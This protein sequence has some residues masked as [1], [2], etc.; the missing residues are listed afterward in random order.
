[1]RPPCFFLL[2]VLLSLAMVACEQKA[3]DAT[4]AN[5]EAIAVVEEALG[6]VELQRRRWL[7]QVERR[8]PDTTRGYARWKPFKAADLD[9]VIERQP[10]T[11]GIDLTWRNIG[12]TTSGRINAHAFDPFDSR[13]IW[14]GSAGGG[15]WKTTNA[16]LS[17]IPMTDSL[18]SLAVSAVAVHP[19]N[20]DILLMG[21]SDEFGL[22]GVQAPQSLQHLR[23]FGAGVIRSIDGGKTWRATTLFQ[24]DERMTCYALTWDRVAVNQVYL[25]ADN[26]VW[27]STNGGVVWRRILEGNAQ[28]VVLNTREP[29]VVYVG[30]GAPSQSDTSYAAPGVWK[31]T[32][33]GQTWEHLTNGLPAEASFQEQC[34]TCAQLALSDA[35]PD[36]LYASFRLV[37]ED[38]YEARIYKTMDGGAQW[39]LVLSDSTLK[40]L[41]ECSGTA[42]LWFVSVSPADPDLAFAGG[43]CLYRT[44]NGGSA[45]IQMG[46]LQ[47]F[48]PLYFKTLDLNTGSWIHV[49]HRAFG[50]DPFDST[51]VYSFTD[52]GV[53]VS[54]D[55]GVI[56]EARNTNLQTL[57]LYGIAS[58]P[59]DSIRL[60]ASAQDQSSL[61][62]H[63]RDKNARWR[64][65]VTGDGTS[66]IFD[67][68]NNILHGVVA[69][70]HHWQFWIP[71]DSLKVPLDYNVART[72]DGIDGSGL[73]KTPMVMDPRTSEVLYTADK[74]TIY[75]STWNDTTYSNGS[76]TSKTWKSLIALDSVSALAL[77]QQK[78]DVV[79][80]YSEKV[81]TPSLWRSLDA[82][83]TWDSLAYSA[84]ESWPGSYVS[85]LEADP[86]TEGTLYATRAGY[87]HLVWRSTDSGQTW[88]DITNNLPSIPANA[89]AVTPDSIVSR[90]Q[91]YVGTD[92]GVY[93]AYAGE[94][95]A[96]VVWHHVGGLPSVEVS[97]MHIHAG[98]RT[99]RVGTFGRGFWKAK[100]PR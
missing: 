66:G 83:L 26:G 60:A 39:D 91:I 54:D 79:Y 52:G 19:R 32:D 34:T 74:E 36:T 1:M 2:A 88:M 28:S 95:S 27:K 11:P 40:D 58:A 8:Q 56:W 47:T 49:D 12:W 46:I 97:D 86:D 93:M 73:W 4:I 63:G 77:D 89:I 92:L 59:S 43:Q 18:P 14:A 24:P 29:G 53:F 7:H 33:G 42:D 13:I 76:A 21:T 70:G 71:L 61:I 30:M 85:D 84:S 72:Q 25:A 5:V 45:W 17:W 55:Q 37:V 41:T 20:S 64:K 75:K 9:S 62:H 94:D 6:Q 80:A 100:L 23:H 38:D 22:G 81:N 44:H 69:G 82:G 67:H 15:L 96:Q 31:S 50:F 35:A 48:D 98:D 10:F 87:S 3:V 78:P 68:T 90:K 65:W 51:R 16:G 57:Q 99:L